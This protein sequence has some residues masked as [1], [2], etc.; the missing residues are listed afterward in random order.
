MSQKNHDLKSIL[1]KHL[2]CNIIYISYKNLFVQ[3]SQKNHNLKSILKNDLTCNTFQKLKKLG[4][5]GHFKL[6]IIYI[7]YKNLFV[8]N[9]PKK[10][11]FEKYFEKTSHMQYFPKIE[12]TGTFGTFILKKNYLSQMSQKNHDLKI[13]L[14]NNIT[15]NNFQKFIILG[16][17]GKN[18]IF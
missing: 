15:C 3:M 17:F 14:K 13:I 6:L 2:T 1:K 16:N 9:V 8:P 4:H 5:L 10:S 18:K 11:R 7:L 12:K